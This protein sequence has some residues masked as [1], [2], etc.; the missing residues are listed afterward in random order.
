MKRIVEWGLRK[1]RRFLLRRQSRVIRNSGR[2]D[3]RY[4]QQH[5][6][7]VAQMAMEGYSRE[8]LDGALAFA[9]LLQN[10][11]EPE[12]SPRQKPLPTKTLQSS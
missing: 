12:L 3:V 2:F 7:D 5:N 1:R 9:H 10:F 4:Y 11:S 6:P 8:E